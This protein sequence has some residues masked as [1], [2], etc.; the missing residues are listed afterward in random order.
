MDCAHD[1][2]ARN[3][4]SRTTLVSRMDKVIDLGESGMVDA[5]SPSS[6]TELEVS[7][8]YAH[9][10]GRL[11]YSMRLASATRGMPCKSLMM[12]TSVQR[13][14]SVPTWPT[15]VPLIS[16]TNQPSGFSFSVAC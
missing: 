11:I 3:T 14:S 6:L 15:M 4:V 2:V 16:I 12:R 9:V 5:P 7:G 8:L 10:S 13:S 1:K